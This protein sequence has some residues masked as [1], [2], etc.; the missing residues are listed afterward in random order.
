[1]E[2]WLWKR[3]WYRH[4]ADYR[5]MMMMMVIIIIIIII[6]TGINNLIHAAA[7]IITPTMNEPSKRSKNRRNVK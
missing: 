3:L 1:V 2:N 7:T 6:I 4:R 5:M